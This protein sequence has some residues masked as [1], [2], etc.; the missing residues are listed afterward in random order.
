MGIYLES[1]E[2]VIILTGLKDNLCLIIMGYVSLK[3]IVYNIFIKVC[4][5]IF[6]LYMNDP[7]R[8]SSNG[9]NSPVENR[10]LIVVKPEN[11]PK[12]LIRFDRTLTLFR[13]LDSNEKY[14]GK[15]VNLWIREKVS[16][17]S[18]LYEK[19]IDA[20]LFGVNSN[21]EFKVGPWGTDL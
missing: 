18:G 13:H 21:K 7:N 20:H 15:L 10:S 17:H 16:I 19:I 4:P 11:P 5:K 3:E 1:Y 9:G 12:K 6:V 8:P 2:V 14:R